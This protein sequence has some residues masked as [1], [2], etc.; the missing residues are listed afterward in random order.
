MR[1]TSEIPYNFNPFI[2]LLKPV[3]FMFQL[4]LFRELIEVSSFWKQWS[5]FGMYI[6]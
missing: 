6:N 4:L 3:M 5:R 1:P 2:W